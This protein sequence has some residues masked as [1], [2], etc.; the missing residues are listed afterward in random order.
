MRV[1]FGL[2]SIMEL[3]DSLS[4]IVGRDSFTR[5]LL[6]RREAFKTNLSRTEKSSLA[7]RSNFS[8]KKVSAAYILTTSSIFSYSSLLAVL[9]FGG[10]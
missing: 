3:K 1:F 2:V 7:I 5:T 6:R 4:A 9:S 10:L 8:T